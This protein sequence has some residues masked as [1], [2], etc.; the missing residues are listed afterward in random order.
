MVLSKRLRAHRASLGYTQAQYG[1]MLGLPGDRVGSLE[2]GCW[3]W[4]M[5]R[6]LQR[7]LARV[8]GCSVAA[9]GLVPR[10]RRSAR[11][12]APVTSAVTTLGAALMD[13]RRALGLTQQD[14]AARLGV[15]RTALCRWEK[16]R[17]KPGRRMLAR[18]AQ[19]LD[20]HSDDLRAFDADARGESAL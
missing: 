4:R 10:S 14:L 15:H 13:R 9:L 11:G 17:I 8:L 19:A 18:L 16:N 7:R 1:A 2:R 3:P 6:P 12:G 20:C 5:P